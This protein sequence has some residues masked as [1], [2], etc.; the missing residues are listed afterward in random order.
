MGIEKGFRILG[1]LGLAAG[2]LLY[3]SS[4]NP[5]QKYAARGLLAT[6]TAIFFLPEAVRAASRAGENIADSVYRQHVIKSLERD[7]NDYSS[8]QFV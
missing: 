6:G 7:I 4:E 5:S 8:Q 1:A 3:R 2:A